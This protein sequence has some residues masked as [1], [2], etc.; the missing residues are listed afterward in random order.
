M[1][2]STGVFVEKKKKKEVGGFL[3]AGGRRSY[4]IKLWMAPECSSSQLPNP[5]HRVPLML[6]RGGRGGGWAERSCFGL[7]TVTAD[8]ARASYILLSTALCTPTPCPL[9]LRPTFC[10]IQRPTCPSARSKNAGAKTKRWMCEVRGLSLKWR[11]ESAI[12][13]AL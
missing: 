11:S 10:N 12:R 7:S 4:S 1:S 9:L 6:G 8:I 3:V 5:C 13:V 2:G